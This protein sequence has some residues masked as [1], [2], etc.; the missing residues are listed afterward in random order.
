M[1]FFFIFFV[2][3]SFGGN[4][5]ADDFLLSFNKCGT[6]YT[7]FALQYLTERP[8]LDGNNQE[9]SFKT[10]LPIRNDRQPIYHSHVPS[11]NA[12]VSDR[13]IVLVRS[14]L[15]IFLRSYDINE[16]NKLLSILSFNR[17][18]DSNEEIGYPS[19]LFL[20][21]IN[22]DCAIKSIKQL[23]SIYDYYENF[24]GD[25]LMVYY[26]DLIL[27]P[28]NTFRKILNFLNEK[29]DKMGE[30]LMNIV[31][32][33]STCQSSYIKQFVG[34]KATEIVR[35]DGKK[36][37]YYQSQ[38]EKKDILQ[39]VDLI[40]TVFNKELHP[41]LRILPDDFHRIASDVIE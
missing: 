14:P 16:V 11:F 5:I 7:L 21:K 30:F 33:Q 35:S 1:R 29:E 24:S 18:F 32:L 27:F 9:M 34:C 28:E 36:I 37:D 6:H 40:K 20:N 8:F 38:Y 2:F 39:T 13:L 41:Y 4:L 31:A 12:N 25:R 19:G 10:G 26:E 23:L 3:F 15:E 22:I 17:P